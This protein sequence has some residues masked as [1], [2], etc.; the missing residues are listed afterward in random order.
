MGLASV[1]F[2]SK[3]GVSRVMRV[4]PVNIPL[5]TDRQPDETLRQWERT[6]QRIGT[7]VTWIMC[8][9]CRTIIRSEDRMDD[10]H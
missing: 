4:V 8:P 3:C 7:V 1:E 5:W 9:E 6:R 10:S 2:C